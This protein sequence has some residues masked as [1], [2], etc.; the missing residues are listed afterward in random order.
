MSVSFKVLSEASLKIG[1]TKENVHQDQSVTLSSGHE[2]SAED[3]LFSLVST[4]YGRR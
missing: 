4:L 1:S 3:T 2:R